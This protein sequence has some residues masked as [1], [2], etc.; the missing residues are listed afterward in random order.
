MVVVFAIIFVSFGNFCVC[1]ET[2]F[3][4]N[5]V[6]LLHRRFI[7]LLLCPFQGVFLF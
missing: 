5:L 6:S 2:V 7:S 1:C 4:Y 3:V